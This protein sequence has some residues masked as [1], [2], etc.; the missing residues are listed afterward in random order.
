MVVK[1]S[2]RYPRKTY[3]QFYWELEQ[4]HGITVFI[5]TRVSSRIARIT[6]D[7]GHSHVL[8]KTAHNIIVLS[9]DESDGLFFSGSFFSEQI[10]RTLC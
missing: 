1:G 5:R 3:R 7:S 10:S 2:K 6:S 8:F 9:F 4:C